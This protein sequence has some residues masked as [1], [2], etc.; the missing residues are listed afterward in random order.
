MTTRS[1]P[2]DVAPL[3]PESLDQYFAAGISTTHLLSRE[4][5]CELLIDPA[6]EVYELLTPA[7]GAEPELVGMQ[8]VT[9]DTLAQDDGPWFRLRIEAH[10]LRH[11]AYGL[12]VAVVQAMRGGASFAA[13]TGAAL[14]NLRSILAARRRL[15]PEQQL[16][17]LGELFVVRRL[18]AAHPEEEVID[19][20]LGPLAEQHD[21]ALPDHDVEVKTTTAERRTH[22]I[23]GTGQLRPNPGRPLWLLSIQ[24]TRAGGAEGLSLSGLVD[25]VRHTLSTRRERF[26]QHLAGL[27][28]RDQDGDLYRERYLL[29]S[30]P[31]AY[32]VDEDFPALTPERLAAAVPH[33][34]LVSAVTYR[35]DVTSRTPELPGGPLD[36]FLS[37]PDGGDV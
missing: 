18:L 32:H 36:L 16:G 28:W 34:D 11:E 12:V 3:T 22:V 37:D 24:V 13:A 29:R 31:A 21:L 10:D 20:W 35:V 33:P 15:N 2:D 27:G 4:P 25:D 23:H 26:V 14:T 19:W 5:R 9:V 30:T 7:I 17:L 1:T 8:R 6:G